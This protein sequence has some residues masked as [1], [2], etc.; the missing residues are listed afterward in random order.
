M[1]RYLIGNVVIAAFLLLFVLIN[2]QAFRVTGEVGYIL[3]AI[4]QS[5][6]GMLF[7]A[8]KRAVATSTSA[9]DWGIAFAA[10][11]L[12]TLLRP[13]HP[14]NA[15]LGDA[16]ISIGII[17]NLASVL[18]LNRSIGMV[19]AQRSIKTGG[20]YR[21]VRHPMYASE[22]LSLFGY[23]LANVS[24]ANAFI[25]ISTAAFMLIR[26]NREELFLSR[27]LAYQAYSI[28]TRWKLLPF[29]Y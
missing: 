6:Y 25:V 8:R 1:L 16:L 26:I 10:T 2:I 4:N 22:V 15:W 12:G 13:A 23:T 14:L 9:F 17:I 18:F 11:F 24:F 28:E 7:L 19:P 20:L 21:Y 3:V 5:V 27:S 29:I